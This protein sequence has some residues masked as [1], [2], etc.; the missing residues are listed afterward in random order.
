MARAAEGREGWGRTTAVQ[1]LG[2]DEDL[3]PQ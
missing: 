2:A 3:G 1:A